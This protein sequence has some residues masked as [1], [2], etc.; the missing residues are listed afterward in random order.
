MDLS[1]LGEVD[2]LQFR[3]GCFVK[4]EFLRAAG[5]AIVA[6]RHARNG[7]LSICFPQGECNK[8]RTWQR[9]RDKR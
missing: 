4:S 6:G 2:D 5:G 9:L 3:Q 1:S 8:I 7:R